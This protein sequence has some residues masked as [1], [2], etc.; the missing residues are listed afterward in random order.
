MKMTSEEVFSQIEAALGPP[1][2]ARGFTRRK[3]EVHPAAFGSRYS[4]YV[5]SM[6]TLRLTW[7]GKEGHFVLECDRLPNEGRAGPW[8]DLVLM[9]FN[10]RDGEGNPPVSSIVHEF[11][12]GLE[13]YLEQWR[14]DA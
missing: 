6:A 12:V 14:N 8:L 5:S 1:L 10:P 9:L 13:G 4:L 11:Q 3:S 7:D 2:R